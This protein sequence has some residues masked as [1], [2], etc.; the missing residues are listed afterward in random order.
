M[1]YIAFLLVAI[2]INALAIFC[3]FI[4]DKQNNK[5]TKINR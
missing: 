4:L 1:G 3:L 2:V 5:K